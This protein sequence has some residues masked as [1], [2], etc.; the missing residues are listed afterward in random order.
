MAF[1]LLSVTD[2]ISKEKIN[3]LVRYSAPE[4]LLCKVLESNAEHRIKAMRQNIRIELFYATNP[5]EI[6]VALCQTCMYNFV[7]CF[8]PFLHHVVCD[9]LHDEIKFYI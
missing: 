7:I 8:F 9:C 5:L 3:F 2:I 6:N 1:N 4:N